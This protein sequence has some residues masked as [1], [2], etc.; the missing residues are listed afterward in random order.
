MN[1]QLSLPDVA[2]LARVQRPVVSMWRR[3]YEEA[4]H[5]FPRPVARQD[6]K[7]VFDADEILR[8]LEATGRAHGR[9]LHGD[10]AAYALPAGLNLS[11]DPAAFEGLTALIALK[12]STDTTLD[13]LT[14]EQLNALAISI[15]P[16]DTC[17]SREVQGLGAQLSK[18]AT[19]ADELVDAAYSPRDALEGLLAERFRHD[20]TDLAASA[21]APPA[22]DLVVA[23]ATGLGVLLGAEGRAYLD[24]T[25]VGS[26]LLLS[27]VDAAGDPHPDVLIAESA[28]SAARLFRRRAAARGL[29][30]A[31]APALLNEARA[32]VI[33]AHYPVVGSPQMTPLEILDSV[34]EVA[35]SMGNHHYAVVIAPAAVLVDR[36]RDRQTCRVREQV[37]RTGL[38]RAALR[39]P[40]GLVTQR[41]R[42][43]LG[44]WILGTDPTDAPVGDRRVA[45]GH[46]PS[47]TPTADC[48]VAIVDDVV[49]SASTL[50]STHHYSNLSL[51]RTARLLADGGSV[52]PGR[53]TQAMTPPSPAELALRVA[54]LSAARTLPGPLQG[55]GVATSSEPIAPRTV[56][57]TDALEA[58]AV[59]VISGNRAGFDLAKGGSVPV[60]GVVELT[61][62][63]AIGSRRVERLAFLGGHGSSRLTEPGDVV[64]CTAPRPRALVD[65][66]GGSAVQFPARIMRVHPV[67]GEGLSPRVIAS[68]IASQPVDA[69]DWRRWVVPL[70][71]PEQVGPTDRALDAL[72]AQRRALWQRLAD[73]ANFTE[74][75]ITG[76]STHAL[77]LHA[78]AS[79]QHL[80]K[81]VT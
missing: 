43:S 57:L 44:I 30:L 51:V 28:T 35:L 34:D 13:G 25:G 54:E 3:R 75:V 17:L 26:D 52:V 47:P 55:L 49:A 69:R 9:D 8:W 32:A 10:A 61:I 5:P 74:L 39:L 29:L 46:L 62:D 16:R 21:L 19:Y 67:K 41:P 45:L 53:R 66:D 15:D 70:L 37:L 24:P 31:S 7:E 56:S 64:F 14:T 2:R 1:L 42:E 36:L 65:A 38:L 4:E 48:I 77:T 27:I 12:A 73:I 6:K 59:R 78:T 50:A 80:Q 23:L 68:T 79:P 18:L 81:E 40:A 58:G 60:L 76:V 22:H 20:A 71:P 72:A 63:G 33:L 11:A